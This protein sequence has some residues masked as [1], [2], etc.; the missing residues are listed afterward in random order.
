MV[1][2]YSSLHWHHVDHLGALVNCTLIA[3]CMLKLHQEYYYTY[4][5][6]IVCHFFKSYHIF[7]C[8]GVIA[9]IVVIMHHCTYDVLTSCVSNRIKST[10]QIL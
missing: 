6:L 10:A 4:Y 7:F 8:P 3:V 1:I 9:L 5:F 2:M